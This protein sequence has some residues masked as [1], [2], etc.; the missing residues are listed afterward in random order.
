MQT[1]PALTDAARAYSS[2]RFDWVVDESFA[3]VPAWQR[4]VDKVFKTAYRRWGR[5][6]ST[7][8]SEIRKFIR[9]LRE[10]R[11]DAIV[12]VQ[13]EWKSAAI[14][15]IARGPR[16]GYDASSV[17]EWGA[18]LLYGTRCNVP[19]G[20]HSI[21]RMRQ[22]LSQ[23]LDYSYSPSDIDYG[24]DRSRLPDHSLQTTLP[25]AVFIHSTSWESKCWPEHYWSELRAL[26][27]SAGYQVVLPWGSE[28]ERKKAN[29]IAGEDEN[30]VVLPRL[31]IAEKAS[32]IS[33]AAFTVGLD[34][35]L[36]HI[37]AAL[38]IPSITIYGATDPK[39]VGATGKNQMHVV[40]D[41]ECVRCHQVVCT[42]SQATAFKPACFVEITPQ[43]VWQEVQSLQA[44]R[45]RSNAPI[46]G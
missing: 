16:R 41:F 5:D 4:N 25:Y 19:K 9:A 33:R 2:I 3:Q 46:G 6:M 15:R 32:I 44:R 30:A 42:Y 39:L 23:A 21:E 20:R 24:I 29:R 11:Y 17:H 8:R 28:D 22:L 31:S 26:T 1:L 7:S 35:G 13:G 38:D 45:S 27:T 43:R 18:H 14:V 40:S 37:A 12:D 36:S 10:E 34:T